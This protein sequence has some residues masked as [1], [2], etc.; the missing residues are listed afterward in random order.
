MSD[1]SLERH[2]DRIQRERTALLSRIEGLSQL[3]LDYQ[4]SRQS[5]SIGQIVHHVGLAEKL[6]RGHLSRAIRKAGP[7]REATVHVSLDDVPFRSRVLPDFLWRNPLVLPPLS[8]MVKLIPRPI[9]AMMFAIPLIKMDAA[10]QMQPKR[11]LSRNQILQ[12]LEE[13]RRTTLDLLR[14]ICDWNLTRIRV[15]HPLVGDQDVC[16][17][18]ELLASHEQ[19]HAQQ[20]DLIKKRASYPRG[21]SGQSA[22]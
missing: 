7:K 9:Q 17:I 2:I 22:V 18:L 5:W 13:T 4:P 11:G 16:G 14:P 8:L 6:W 10:P 20:I 1:C 19:R 3:Q 12:F 21:G 15:V